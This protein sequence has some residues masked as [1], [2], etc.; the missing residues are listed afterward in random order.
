MT[1]EY[2]AGAVIFRRTEEGPLFLLLKTKDH[3]RPPFAPYWDF[4][5]GHIEAGE[6]EKAAARREIQEETGL[7]GLQF[8]S[9]FREKVSY[10]FNRFG[11]DIEKTVA[12]FLAET[13][14]RE[15]KFTEPHLAF[16]WFT[17]DEALVNLKYETSRRVLAQAAFFLAPASHHQGNH[18]RAVERQHNHPVRF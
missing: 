8:I 5:K 4:P 14:T 18:K 3:Y 17:K 16:G 12:Y 2:S 15:I 1:K 7:T 6:T 13:K 11:Q 10:R 9:S